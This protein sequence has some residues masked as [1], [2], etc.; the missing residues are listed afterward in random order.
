MKSG[1]RRRIGPKVG[2]GRPFSIAIADIQKALDSLEAQGLVRKTGR[3]R[4][5]RNGEPLPV[6]VAIPVNTE[7]EASP[8]RRPRRDCGPERRKGRS[9]NSHSATGKPTV[10]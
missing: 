8:D 2:D 3:F 7:T 1:V 9:E 10:I 5:A 6:Y 4:R